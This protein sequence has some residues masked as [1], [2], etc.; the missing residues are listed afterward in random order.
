MALLRFKHAYRAARNASSRT[1]SCP[2]HLAGRPG[3]RG[4]GRC[5]EPGQEVCC[6]EHAA[7]GWRCSA[8]RWRTRGRRTPMS[9]AS[10]CPRRCRRRLAGDDHARPCCVWLPARGRRAEEVGLQ[11]FAPPESSCP[12][13]QLLPEAPDERPCSWP[14]PSRAM[15][16]SPSPQA[17][18]RRC[19]GSCVPITCA[20]PSS[21][22]GHWWRYRYDKF[23]WT[24]RSSPAVRAQAAAL[25]Q[26]D[27]PRSAFS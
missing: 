4:D 24:T 14:G 12:R 17:P 19:C 5:R 23:G 20:S 15:S 26:P 2:D 1:T 7:P 18:W 3:V 11:P 6:F 25:G 8:S 10:G 16:T 9:L 13:P 22:L 21:P 27:V